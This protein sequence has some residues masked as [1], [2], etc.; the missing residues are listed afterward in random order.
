MASQ[1]LGGHLEDNLTLVELRRECKIRF[2]DES[3]N[4]VVSDST[5]MF[6]HIIKK[7]IIIHK[8]QCSIYYENSQDDIQTAAHVPS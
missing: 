5:S 4:I 6:F 3:P 2:G 8:K 7:I 1:W